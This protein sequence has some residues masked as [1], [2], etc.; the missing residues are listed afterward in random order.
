MPLYEFEENQW[1]K[2]K[3]LPDYVKKEK[4]D[5]EAKGRRRINFW[6]YGSGDY[7]APKASYAY[8]ADAAE[9]IK[10]LIIALH[11][12]N[13]ECILELFFPK[14]MNTTDILSILHF[15]V[16]RYHV[17][18]FHLQGE[19]MPVS[20]LAQDYLLSETK[21]GYTWFDEKTRAQ[22]KNHL[23]IYNEEFVNPLRR[24]LCGKEANLYEFAN[25]MR[26]QRTDCGSINYIADNNGFS[27][28]D[29]FS[30][31]EKH[32]EDNGENNLDGNDWNYSCNCGIE[33][34]T[35]Q[36]YVRELRKKLMRNALTAVFL[37]QG[38]PLLFSGDEFGNS[39]WGNNNAY[40]QD[41][42]TGWVNWKQKEKN[43]DVVEL[44][45]QLV[46]FRREH[47]VLSM[48]EPMQMYDYKGIGFPDLS[49]HGEEAWLSDFAPNRQAFGILY[50][51]GYAKKA[52][53]TAD[54]NIYLA[55]NFHQAKKMLALPLQEKGKEWYCVFDT[56]EEKAV[57]GTEKKLGKTLQLELAAQ[58][59]VL[60]VGK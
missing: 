43:K 59:V 12:N 15:W 50:A 48:T 30:Y 37:A 23:L 38:I 45:K 29:L 8:S 46:S 21:I 57:F 9:E 11:K 54:D 2:K 34:E 14:G 52:D 47:P 7:F 51:G 18:G 1:E 4:Q 42:V 60:L 41:N 25:Q 28:L 17:D 44:V 24:M 6:G 16:M 53:G 55:F 58:S 10:N 32:N 49:Y 26:K 13:M 5:E 22:N 39:K 19:D 56:A 20:V 36:R 35:R 31:S 40:C 27:L 3:Q 33:G